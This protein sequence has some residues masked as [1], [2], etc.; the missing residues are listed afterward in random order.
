MNQT[1]TPSTDHIGQRIA[2]VRKR[3]SLSQHGLAART[4]YSRSHIAQ[5][6]TGRKVATPAFVAAAA[7]GLSV[8]ISELYGQPYFRDGSDE[9]VHGGVS[10]LR[11]LLAYVGVGPEL[12]GPPRS[13]AELSREV[14]A[15]RKLMLHARITTLVGVLPA[16]L[17]ELTFWAYET[18]APDAW[19]TLNRGQALAVSLTRRLGYSGDS[20]AW[21]ERAADSAVR[22]GDPH[23]PL[24]AT[25]PR[26]LL[27][28]GMS[29][30]RPALALLERAM[31]GVQDDRDDAAEVRG[32]LALRAA[33][34]AA[35]AK[36]STQ[37]WDNYEQAREVHASGRMGVEQH[38]VQ[39]TAENVAIHGAAVAVEL[40]DLDEASCRDREI[41]D[42]ALERLVP[43]RRT[44]HLIDMARLHVETGDYPRATRR[45]LAAE[46]I[47]PQMTRYHPSARSVVEHLVDVR[48][49]LPEPLRGIA[50]R[51]GV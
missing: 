43:E 49:E 12:D 37:A 2:R 26:A 27:L 20:L 35:R 16:L 14:D 51:M 5:V 50:H 6:E 1:S 7:A 28:M 11:R 48:R 46:R 24:L 45:V 15:G 33:I 22:S 4:G 41:D 36:N 25:A 38:A 21:M 23:L 31:A 29:Q 47:A 30:Y 34:V 8:D 39:F 42:E 40:G 13:L 3:R 32:Y 10:D 17:E 44:H 19:A 18:D 9:Q